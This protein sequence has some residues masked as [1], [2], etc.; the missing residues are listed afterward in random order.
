M[1]G[2]VQPDQG[3]VHQVSGHGNEQ[4]RQPEPPSLNRKRE[5]PFCGHQTED[6]K[7]ER[8][9]QN[10]MRFMQLTELFEVNSAVHNASIQ[11]FGDASFRRSADAAKDPLKYAIEVFDV[12]L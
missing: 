5:R 2:L 9:P 11:Q 6:K 4:H 10:P 7:L 3:P 8:L 1:G 12:T